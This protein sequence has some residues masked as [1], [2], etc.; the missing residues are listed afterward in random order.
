MAHQSTRASR[1]TPLLILAWLWVGLPFAYGVYE[2]I[3]KLT[4]L[5]SG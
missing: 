4:Q 2:L 3:L 5:F 1:H